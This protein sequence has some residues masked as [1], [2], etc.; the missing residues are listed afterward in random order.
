MLSACW[1]RRVLIVSKD[2][3][4]LLSLH[5]ELR[6]SDEFLPSVA[7]GAPEALSLIETGV[8]F[9]VVL[10]DGAGE[11]ADLCED[12][13]RRL[14]ERNFDRPIIMLADAEGELSASIGGP[15]GPDD[16]ISQ[17]AKTAVLLARL[18][19]HSDARAGAEARVFTVGPYEFRP[20]ARLLYKDGMK[21]VLTVKETA[22]LHR[23]LMAG[24]KPVDRRTLLDQI[25]GYNAL[26]TTH[27]L[28][29][30]VYRLRQ[31]I[32]RDPRCAALVL[33]SP[34]GY[35]VAV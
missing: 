16:I 24:G 4:L 5:S 11:C 2:R 12:L 7:G 17:Y 6:S 20:H 35:C 23:L 14:R 30:H 27:T 15:S 3:T 9:D 1:K 28:E 13:C 10:V 8:P 26:V 21:I 34:N 22:I 19:A 29:T 33:T 31:K 32:E 18:R 25:W